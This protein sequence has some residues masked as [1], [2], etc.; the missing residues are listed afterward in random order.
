M[1]SRTQVKPDAPVKPTDLLIRQKCEAMILYGY[2]ALRQFP[3]FERHVLAAEMRLSMLGLS[4][5]DLDALFVSGA[6]L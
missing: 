6:K 4:G 1:S 2:V 3:A 5:A